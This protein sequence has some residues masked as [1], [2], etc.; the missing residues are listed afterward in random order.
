MPSRT[1]KRKLRVNIVPTNKFIVPPTIVNTIQNNSK[2]AGDCEIDRIMNYF[3]YIIDNIINQNNF[4]DS[5]SHLQTILNN[6]FIKTQVE[7]YKIMEIIENNLVS[8]VMNISDNINSNIIACRIEYINK[9]ITTLPDNIR[10]A[11]TLPSMILQV[12]EDII[13]GISFNNI[14]TNINNITTYIND[15][16]GIIDKFVDIQTNILGI[17]DNISEGIPTG[18][19]AM[20]SQTVKSMIDELSY[21]VYI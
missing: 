20:R 12:I 16:Y 10:C 19:I 15:K 2:F 14:I 17:I 9:L 5:I 11:E 1:Y 21:L 3:L 6:D 4:T 18:I 8:T 13:A 7:Y